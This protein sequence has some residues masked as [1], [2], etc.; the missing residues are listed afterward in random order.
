MVVMKTHVCRKGGAT[1]GIVRGLWEK[2]NSFDSF[3]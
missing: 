1:D 2:K 3:S